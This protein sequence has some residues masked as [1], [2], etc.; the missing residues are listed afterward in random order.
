M[1][2]DNLDHK[3]LLEQRDLTG[4]QVKK[5][6]HKCT[7][8]YEQDGAIK[9]EH[10]ENYILPHHPCVCSVGSNILYRHAEKDPRLFRGA[11]EVKIAL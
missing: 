3:D 11:G 2:L 9:E 5:E 7:E 4:L 8:T 6:L 10:N 1:N